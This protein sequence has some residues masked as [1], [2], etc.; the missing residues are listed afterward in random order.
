MTKPRSTAGPK[1]AGNPAPASSITLDI[2]KHLQGTSDAHVE[3]MTDTGSVVTI[4]KFLPTGLPV[5]DSML[6]GGVPAGRI[7]EL[8]SKGEGQGKSSL[9]ASLMTEMQRQGGTVVLMDTEHGFTE[10]RLRMFGVDPANVIF[11]EPNH[12]ESACQIISDTL[13]YLKQQEEVE[14]KV[15][16]VW[17]SVTATPSKSEYEADYGQIQV[18][19][20]AR[21]WSVNIKKLKDEIAKS[22]CYVVMVN[23]TRT[24]IG[25]MFGEKQITTGGMAI[26]YY[27]GCR[28]VLYREQASWLKQGNERIGF[29]TTMMMEKSRIAAPYHKAVAYLLFDKGFDRQK[30]LFDLLLSLEIITQKGGW[31]EMVGV[32]K[33]FQQSKFAAALEE[34]ALDKKAVENVK[35]QLRKARLTDEAI[36]SFF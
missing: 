9:A 10:E 23:Q 13:K 14:G 1:G 2:V 5:I 28:L 8:F 4:P 25:Q 34:L 22:E 20:A 17:D 31:Y 12:I 30:A 18:A 24:N 26:K 16:I 7:T 3:R 21:A 35:E 27:A 15:L 19:S 33:S 6:G 11:V 36:S 29:K 32:A